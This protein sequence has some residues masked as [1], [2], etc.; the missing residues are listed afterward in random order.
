MSFSY[1][2]TIQLRDTDAAG[3]VYFAN[4]ISIC[5]VAYEASLIAANIN[6]KLLVNN[7]E[8]AVPI[9]HVSADFFKPLYCGDRV[10][11]HLTPRSIDSCR[12]EI[13][14]Q[15][16][17]PESLVIATAVTKHITIA[18]QTR[19]RRELTVSLNQWLSQWGE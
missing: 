18:P 2:Y 19:K 12:F 15:L 1:E 3:V 13:K 16:L 7:Q 14:Y 10:I 5:H 6:L 17:S 11:I 8:F 4:I 9:T